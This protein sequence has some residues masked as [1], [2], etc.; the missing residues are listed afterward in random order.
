MY[1][2]EESG[3]DLSAVNGLNVV[4]IAP[5]WS[6]NDIRMSGTIRYE[7]YSE[8]TGSSAVNARLD[9]VSEFVSNETM[10]SF[11]GTWMLLVEWRD[12]PPFPA[13]DLTQAASFPDPDYLT[14]VSQQ[15]YNR[16]NTYLC[17]LLQY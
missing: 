9:E 2:P 5:F 10:N 11:N 17:I 7:S 16:I 3:T 6:N 14:L 8:A 15:K 12:C 4:A 1:P 13:G